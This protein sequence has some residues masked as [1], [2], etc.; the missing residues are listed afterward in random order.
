[1]DDDDI[2]EIDLDNCIQN[3]QN[4]CFSYNIIKKLIDYSTS[5]VIVFNKKNFL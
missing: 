1:M 4:T 3:Y 5:K 2:V